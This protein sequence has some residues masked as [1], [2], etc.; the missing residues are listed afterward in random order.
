M[1]LM[2]DMSSAKIIHPPSWLSQNMQYACVM[3]SLA[4]GVSGES[5]D[6]DVYGFT[7]PPKKTVFPHLAGEI[8]GFGNQK[9]RFDQWSE[10][11]REWKGKEYDFAIYSIVRFFSL[12]MDNNPNMVD[13]LFVPANCIIHSTKIGNIVRENRRLFLHRG[14]WPKF[15]G[16]AYSQLHKISIKTP[17]HGSKRESEVLEHGY[18]TKFAYHCVRLLDEVEQI[19]TLGD[20]DLQRSREHLKAIRRGE[21]KEAEIREFFSSKEKS[22]EKAYSDS[23]LPWGPREPEIRDLLMKCLETHYGE[24]PV[25][26]EESAVSA[27]REIAAVCGRF[28]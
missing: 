2:N 14:C 8:A 4:Y 22:L 1:K 26:R 6:M 15:K 28:V 3:G 13:S 10:H 9:K 17:D 23:D 25:E 27:L 21:V 20:L 24:L 11:H 7:I 16:Y 19:L 12:C 18:D 5:S